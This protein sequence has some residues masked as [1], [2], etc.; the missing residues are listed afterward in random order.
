MVWTVRVVIGAV[1]V[2][3]GFAKSID[4][5]GSYY[6][7][8]EYL[9]VWG[10]DIPS[11][12]VVLAAFAL[13]GFEFVWGCLLLLGCYRRVAV[14]LLLLMMAFMLPLTLYIAIADPVA[15][16]GCFGDFWIISNT[17]TFLKNIVITQLL[18][19]LAVFN[20]RVD[21]LFFPYVQ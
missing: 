20:R 17:A 13:G 14:W 2:V 19:Y 3:S 18:L 9:D 8:Y 16:C 4:P 6:K 21:G 15:D 5:W 12:L 1:F 11:A 10:W 7:I